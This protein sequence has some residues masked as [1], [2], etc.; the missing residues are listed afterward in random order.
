[1]ERQ[2]RTVAICRKDSLFVGSLEAGE[3]F[4]ILLTVML[5]CMLVGA[6]PYEYMADVISKIASDSPASR[7]DELLPR[8]WQAAR[9]VAEEQDRGEA[10]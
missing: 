10:R 6:N 5:N 8:Q 7:L 1:M 4:S 9:Q 2:I 3:R